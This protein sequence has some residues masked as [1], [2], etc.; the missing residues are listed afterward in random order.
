MKHKTI[1]WLIVIVAVVSFILRHFLQPVFAPYFEND[2]AF[3][4]FSLA[5]LLF[6]ILYF[7]KAREQKDM[8]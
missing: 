8:S 5:E 2:I 7:K 3:P 6:V 4:V 1:Q